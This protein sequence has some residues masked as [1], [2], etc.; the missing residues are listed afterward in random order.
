MP[1]YSFHCIG[2][3][4]IIIVCSACIILLP[5]HFKH[6]QIMTNCWVNLKFQCWI[7]LSGCWQFMFYNEFFVC[8]QIAIQSKLYIVW[9]WHEYWLSVKF[10]IFTIKEF[11]HGNHEISSCTISEMLSSSF[12]YLYNYAVIKNVVYGSSMIGLPLVIAVSLQD[13]PGIKLGWHTSEAYFGHIE[14]PTG[15]K[16]APIVTK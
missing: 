4:S 13:M 16:Y 10:E 9:L 8:L 5:P 1:C 7:E 3:L 14:S 11:M 2:I 6:Y 12:G 15:V